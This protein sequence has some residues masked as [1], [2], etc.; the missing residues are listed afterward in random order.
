VDP[1]T[2]TYWYIYLSRLKLE[3][4]VSLIDKKRQ[5]GDISEMP[6]S[7]KTKGLEVFPSEGT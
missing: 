6:R 2:L 1:E 7:Q 5:G 3:K 4:T